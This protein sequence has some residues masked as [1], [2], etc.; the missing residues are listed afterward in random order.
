VENFVES[1]KFDLFLCQC[2]ECGQLYIG[3]FLEINLASGDDDYWNFW[4][5]V[6]EEEI[7]AV[8]NNH[9]EGINLIQSK[10]HIVHGPS[11]KVYWSDGPEIAL[12]RG[13]G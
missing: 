2:K 6:T 7:A 13:P 11:G 9:R 8:R 10:K 12:V 1:D 4:V 3:C 5:P